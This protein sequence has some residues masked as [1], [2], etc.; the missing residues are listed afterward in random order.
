VNWI[1]G[2]DSIAAT[3]WWSGFFFWASI[4]SLIG[5]GISEVASHR[6]ADRKDELSADQQ[7]VEKKAHDEEMARL[8]LETAQVQERAAKLEKEAA[9]ANL[10]LGRLQTPR[11]TLLTA[12]ALDSIAEKLQPFAGTRFDTGLAANSGEQADFLWRLEMA[13][14]N[15]P[16]PE[17]RLNA[18]WIEIPWG[19]N[20]VG[21]GAQALRRGT[22]PVSGSVAAQNVEIHLHPEYRAKLL[23]AATA[24]I[25]ALNDVGI[26]SKE[27]GF[28][29]YSSNDDAIHVLIGEKQ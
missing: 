1:P 5:L 14:T 12:A 15:L 28:N 11:A 7:R 2:W 19:F 16:P 13:L 27:V 6:Y 10:S 9:E 18:G 4:V 17:N 20:Q 24:L 3:G 29:T 22:R 8:H 21:V 23:P 25:S 26:I